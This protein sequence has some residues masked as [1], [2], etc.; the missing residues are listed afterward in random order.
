MHQH[1]RSVLRKLLADYGPA[2][3]NEP[4]R[5]DAF[6]ADLCGPYFCERFL[7]VHALRVRNSIADWS[8]GHWLGSCSQRLQKRYCLSAEAAQ[9][10]VESW[11][12]ALD[13]AP[14][15]QGISLDLAEIFESPR[16]TLSQLLSAYGP[17]LLHDPARVDAF[18]ADLCCGE[19]PRERFLLVHALR[20]W[21]PS[22]LLVQDGSGHESLLSQRLQKRYGFSAQAVQ[23]TIASW[24]WALQNARSAHDRR[25]AEAVK[26]QAAAEAAVR[27]KV[28]ERAAADMTAHRKAEERAAADEFARQ[29]AR[30]RATAYATARLKGEECIAADTV[31]HQKAKESTAADTTASQLAEEWTATKSAARLIAEEVEEIMLQVMDNN[32]MT[33][34]EVAEF[35][36]KEQEQTIT[37][38]RRLQEAGKVEFV[39]LKRSPSY[40]CYQRR[41]GGNVPATADE[42][43]NVD[44]I[45]FEMAARVRVKAQLAVEAA[46]HEK[47]REKAA[48][49]TTARLKAKEQTLAK[50][51]ARQ[52]A[53]ELDEAEAIARRKLGEQGAAEMTARLKAREQAAA[54]MIVRYKTEEQATAEESAQRKA[55]ERNTAEAVALQKKKEWLAT[56]ATARRRVE[57]RLAAEAEIQQKARER[58]AT[59]A[60]D[61][62]KEV[63]LKESVLQNLDQGPITS[64]ELAKALQAEQENVIALLNQLVKEELIERI[65][66]P[67]SR[68]SPCYA[69]KIRPDTLGPSADRS[70]PDQHQL[71]SHFREWL[72]VLWLWL[73][74]MALIVLPM[75]SVVGSEG[76][77]ETETTVV[78]IAIGI[79]MGIA[80]GLIGLIGMIWLWCG[81]MLMRMM[82]MEGSLS[83]RANSW[84]GLFWLWAGAMGLVGMTGS[85]EPTI[86]LA[87][88]GV[89]LIGMFWLWLGRGVQRLFGSIVR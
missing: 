33:S 87:G 14:A 50:A 3:L 56:E 83:P 75:L 32:P 34:D 48:A 61:R 11:S 21:I 37:W 66:L 86:G 10:A 78:L 64:R 52:K 25:L 38:L 51:A 17:D 30:E 29:K 70:A 62:Q 40:P 5:V 55:K 39:W 71:S 4:A 76:L 6:L 43:W 73:G 85:F 23:S 16:H 49:E 22:S 13:I 42:T 26:A 1:P 74:T 18:L 72:G 88:L 60:T 58:A 45:E 31:A 53:T 65:W 7:L 28:E 69:I 9:W 77:M 47:A 79:V 59:E 19:Y 63:E 44:E 12:A 20:E 81:R 36:G 54:E 24:S 2:L 41:K 89:G 27:L 15:P 80:T 46:V 57:E 8:V 82:G 84:M 67:R 35:L 68:Y